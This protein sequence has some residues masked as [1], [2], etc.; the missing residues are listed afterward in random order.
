MIAI[1]GSVAIGISRVSGRVGTSSWGLAFPSLVPDRRT[2]NPGSS[3][4]KAGMR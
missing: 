2:T 1:V 3:C 4:G